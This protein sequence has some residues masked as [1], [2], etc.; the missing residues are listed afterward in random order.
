MASFSSPTSRGLRRYLPI[1][2]VLRHY[3]RMDF[4]GDLVAGLIVAV[5]LIPQAM[6]YALLAG[7]PP[8]VGLYASTLPLFAYALFGS[9]KQLAVGPVAIVSLIT[10]SSIA[11]IAGED[12]TLYLRLAALLALMVGLI[13][14]GLGLLRAGFI[15]NFL[16]HAVIS[17]FTSA[18][19]IVIGLSQLG[20]LLGVSLGSG[21]GVLALLWQVL[22]RLGDIHWLTL[23]LGLASIGLLLLLKGAWRSVGRYLPGPL[24][25]VV[26]STLLVYALNLEALGVRIVGAVPEGLPPLLLPNPA[27]L[28]WL[29][30][31]QALLPA[32]L[33]ISF[34]GFIESVAVA[35]A[36]AAK[37][38]D[39]IDSNQELVGLGVANLVAGMFSGYPVTG[40]FSRSAVNAQAGAR[41]PV[42]SLIT[43]ALIM[44]TLLFFTPLFYYLPRAVLAAIIMVAVYG[45]IDLQE[46]RHLFATKAIDGWTLLL[47]FAATLLIG[48]EEGIVIGAAFSLL[49]FIWRS[50]YPHSTELGY[51]PESDIFRNVSRYPEARTFA[52][53]LIVRVDASLY[54]ANMTFLENW[55]AAAIQH[56]EQTDKLHYLILD[57]SGVNDIDAVALK[58]LA[59]MMCLLEEDGVATHIANMKGPVRDLAKKA[60]WYQQFQGRISHVS[61]HYALSDLGLLQSYSH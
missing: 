18:A 42:A 30:A 35:K 1:V 15:T 11:P 3:R 29:E 43:A 38:Q 20:Q 33:T 39:K 46:A 54:F 12:V 61:L 40:G 4:A 14:T 56:K 6:A 47:T 21:H 22:A 2:D 10:F 48:I 25:V 50:A 13:Q 37:N 16:S 8:I 27:G 52:H 28:A 57:F 49:V 24:L 55:L 53:T 32:A 5:M 41:T 31:M 34:V 9:S 58:T 7:L 51:L 44:L 60:G 23:L 36:L 19:A 59:T 17:G 45:L 26:L